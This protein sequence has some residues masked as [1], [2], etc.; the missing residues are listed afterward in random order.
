MKILSKLQHLFGINLSI[1]GDIQ[2]AQ[3]GDI[4]Y[5][6]TINKFRKKENDIISDISV[7]DTIG[8]V[9]D[10]N[11]NYITAGL[12]G[13]K[14]IPSACTIKDFDIIAN[15]IGSIKFDILVNGVSIVGNAHPSLVNSK[16]IN[17]L[18]LSN[19]SVNL[20]AADIVDF[21]VI[22]QPTVNKVTLSLII[23]K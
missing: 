19:W 7:L 3:N 20:N 18:N 9:V 6:S 1:N 21:V 12:K 5:N 4:W 2:N 22:E 11:T 14:Y 10:A 15:T 8:V 17:N 16:H 23:Q 13:S